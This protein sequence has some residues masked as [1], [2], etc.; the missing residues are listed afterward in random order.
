[1]KI[2]MLT[3][4]CICNWRK[5]GNQTEKIAKN[6]YDFIS[7]DRKLDHPRHPSWHKIP[8]MQQTLPNYDWVFWQI[9]IVL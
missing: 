4:E 3:F 5:I 1:M 6:G 9:P 8:Y 7:Y 2:A